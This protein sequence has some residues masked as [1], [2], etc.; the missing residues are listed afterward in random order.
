MSRSVEESGK[1]VA[2]L[3]ELSASQKGLKD[4]IATLG[5]EIGTLR[6]AYITESEQTSKRQKLLEETQSG[7]R[8]W[9][10]KREAGFPGMRR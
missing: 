9:E 10:Q 3:A 2:R 8:K 1:W 5:K 7:L 4:T 6:G